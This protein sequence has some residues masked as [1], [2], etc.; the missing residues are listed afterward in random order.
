MLSTHSVI[1]DKCHVNIYINVMLI[2]TANNTKNVSDMRL[3]PIGLLK[4]V[5][6]TK[7]PQYIFYRSTP[8]A[9]ILN[10][11]EFQNLV[12]M[13]EDYM[14]S[15]KAKKFEKQNKKKIKWLDQKE[16]DKSVSR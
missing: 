10:I 12:E 14:D 3:D 9:V 5:E 13:A 2:P 4:I 1:I 15:L 16:F 11:E 8:K 6:K 7:G